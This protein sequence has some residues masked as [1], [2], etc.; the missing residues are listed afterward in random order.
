MD[1]GDRGEALEGILVGLL[2]SHP[3]VTVRVYAAAL[4]G[5]AE[6]RE[7]SRS[8]D[9]LLSVGR[10]PSTEVAVRAAAI[11]AL[12]NAPVSP[13]LDQ[14]LRGALFSEDESLAIPAARFLRARAEG[15]MRF[16]VDLLHSMRSDCA[17]ALVL[18]ACPTDQDDIRSLLASGDGLAA[19]VVLSD[20]PD[21]ELE[22]YLPQ[23]SDLVLS[24]NPLLRA[25]ALCRLPETERDHV[26]LSERM[27]DP[28]PLARL[29]AAAALMARGINPE[30]DQTFRDLLSAI[31]THD[32]PALRKLATDLATGTVPTDLRPAIISEIRSQVSSTLDSARREEMLTRFAK[33]RESLRRKFGREARKIITGDDVGREQVLEAVS[34]LAWAGERADIDTLL[35]LANGM[36]ALQKSCRVSVE[37]LLGRSNQGL[38]GGK[39]L[40]ALTFWW[41]QRSYAYEIPSLRIRAW[42]TRW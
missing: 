34:T 39:G 15:D 18:P 19:A 22:A 40:D 13:R 11:D 12:R 31:R 37:A 33:S 3:N 14:L 35:V 41:K 6:S 7:G 8:V 36:S 28:D 38:G 10:N 24:S 26:V 9:A 21:S 4:L 29:A 23:I 25:L 30:P 42:S 27:R 1:F 20:L 2:R 5:Q 17:R 16:D 32:L